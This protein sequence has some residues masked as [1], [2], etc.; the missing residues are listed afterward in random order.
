MKKILLTVLL[1]TL[2]AT[3]IQAKAVKKDFSTVI[4]DSGVDI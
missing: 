4:N 3:N 2:F 1:M